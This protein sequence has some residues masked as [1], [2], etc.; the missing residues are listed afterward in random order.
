MIEWKFFIEQRLH[1][2]CNKTIQRLFPINEPQAHIVIAGSFLKFW[3]NVLCALWI[4]TISAGYSFVSP[5]SFLSNNLSHN[6]RMVL[7]T[8]YDLV[9]S[10]SHYDGYRLQ[11]ELYTR[12]DLY[13]W[14]QNY[15]GKV[16]QS[17]EPAR[18][19][20]MCSTIA[21]ILYCTRR[22]LQHVSIIKYWRLSYNFNCRLER[23]KLI[24]ANRK[25]T[26]AT[27]RQYVRFYSASL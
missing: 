1:T 16:S 14:F 15:I 21:P 23:R 9:T 20:L 5:G 27:K 24:D 6:Y 19:K 12:S 7:S 25:L 4:I 18:F 3:C 22:T 2:N 13:C 17:D 11:P 8:F 26:N 10:F